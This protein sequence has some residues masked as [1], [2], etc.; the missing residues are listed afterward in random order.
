MPRKASLR[1]ELLAA[2]SLLS[3]EDVENAAMVLSRGAVNLPELADARTVAAYVSVGREP[4]TRALLDALHARGAQVLLP[5]LLPDNDL[6]WAAY[7]GG[8]SLVPAA[9]G[10][11]EPDGPRLGP[12]AVLDADVVLLPGLA[13][14]GRGMRLG[15]GGGSYDRVLARLAAAGAHPALVVLLYDNEVVAQVP[16]E[17]HDH[18]VDAVVT[19]AGARR[20]TV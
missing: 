8:D 19:P 4:G 6:D 16:V 10:L 9:R 15:R 7:E 5:V 14:D 13:V 3:R 17:P 2:R 11:L 1:R 18:P 12:D 20:F